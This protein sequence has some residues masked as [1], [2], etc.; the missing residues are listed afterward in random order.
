MRPPPRSSLS[1]SSAASDGYKRRASDAA[2]AAAAAQ[3][4]I[5]DGPVSS[6]NGKAGVVSL[7][8][9]D[10]PN[11]TQLIAAKADA[12]HGHT[13]AQISNLQTT[14][15]SL[16]QQITNLVSAYDGGTY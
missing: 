14:L 11:L 7:G 15:T 4:A 3:D 12:S 10:I 8:V 13:I 1:S 16:Q 5:A 2:I 9:S 6:V